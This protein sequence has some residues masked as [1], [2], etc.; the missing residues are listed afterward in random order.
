M[1]CLTCINKMVLYYTKVYI[2][3]LKKNTEVYYMFCF[4]ISCRL[5]C[6]LL[7]FIIPSYINFL[8][9]IFHLLLMQ[10]NFVYSFIISLTNIELTSINIISLIYVKMAKRFITNCEALNRQS[11]QNVVTLRT[12]HTPKSPQTHT[13]HIFEV[14]TNVSLPDFFL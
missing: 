14:H 1:F 9:S 7:I 10:D 2:Y 13:D 6:A 12:K 5:N 11:E 3:F 8:I 4:T